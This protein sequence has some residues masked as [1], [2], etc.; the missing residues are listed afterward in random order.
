MHEKHQFLNK[1]NAGSFLIRNETTHSFM[2]VV[3]CLLLYHGFPF[4]C[5]HLND[6]VVVNVEASVSV[7]KP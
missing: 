3:R 1:T 5:S 7:P 4:P 6:V 2:L